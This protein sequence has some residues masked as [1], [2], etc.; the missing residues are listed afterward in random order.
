MLAR[1]P[2]I[3]PTG[4]EITAV[5]FDMDGLLLDTESLSLKSFI[6]TARRYDLSVGINEYRQLIGLNAVAGLD[7][8]R[9]ILPSRLDPLHF[10]NEWLG[11]Y[12]DLLDTGITTK[13]GAY[14]MLV[15]LQAAQIR[16]AVATS[17]AGHKARRILGDVGLLP[18]IEAV[19]GGDEVTA[20]KPEPYVYLD[21]AAKL[22]VDPTSCLALEDSEN[23]VSAALAAGM[24]VIQI[25]DLA[26]AT[27]PADTP[28]F[29]TATSLADAARLI[30]LRL[31]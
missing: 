11:V 19:T 4:T 12:R 17:S 16:R 1:R 8:L 26:P 30:G 24:T 13:P 7:I 29:Y 27:R 28:R 23:G 21:A 9:G 3:L 18:M 22:G 15:A 6:T 10:K 5:I 2:L 31:D 14:T 25:P 20:G